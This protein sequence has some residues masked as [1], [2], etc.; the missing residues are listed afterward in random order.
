MGRELETPLNRYR[1]V[2]LPEWVDYNGHM[3]EAAYLTAFGW[4]SDVLFRCIGDDE[5]YR[6]AGHSF[7]TC[8]LYTS[9]AADE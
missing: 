9:D 5:A 7:Y 4:A 2:V 6:A 3:T 1:G 8:L